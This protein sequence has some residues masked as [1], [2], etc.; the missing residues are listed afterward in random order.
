MPT[1]IKVGRKWTP[2]ECADLRQAMRLT[3]REMAERVGVS[4]SAYQNWEQGHKSP[5]PGNKA[6][7]DA[8]LAELEQNRR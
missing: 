1:A 8:L 6:K 4:H 3:M 7:L 5:H 2:K